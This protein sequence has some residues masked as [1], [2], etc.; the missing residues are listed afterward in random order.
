[1]LQS[2]RENHSS[3]SNPLLCPTHSLFTLPVDLHVVA[4]TLMILLGPCKLRD[5]AFKSFRNLF[6]SLFS[7]GS[8]YV[9]W[10]NTSYSWTGGREKLLEDNGLWGRSLSSHP[11]LLR[12]HE[13]SVMLVT[14]F[15]ISRRWR[16]M[17]A[18]SRTLH[19]HISPPTSARPVIP[20]LSGLP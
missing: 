2:L 9:I 14:T 8:L 5:P 20:T 18:S 10:S 6:S 17:C 3:Q 11:A 16:N 4:F 12:A 13:L 7:A 1:M 19:M 15:W